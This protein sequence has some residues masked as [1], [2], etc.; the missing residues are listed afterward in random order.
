MSDDRIIIY[1]EKF[2]SLSDPNVL[3]PSKQGVAKK[4]IYTIHES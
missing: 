2:N 3:N 4:L 1:V